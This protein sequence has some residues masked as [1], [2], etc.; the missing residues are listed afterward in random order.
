MYN[1]YAKDAQSTDWIHKKRHWVKGDA[2]LIAN[3]LFE[4]F[5]DVLVTKAESTETQVY[6]KTR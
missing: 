2:I 3:S 4:T 1:I 5:S 6:R